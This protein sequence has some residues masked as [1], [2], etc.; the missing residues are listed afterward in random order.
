MAVVFPV[1]F[2]PTNMMTVGLLSACFF[3]SQASKSNWLTFRTSDTASLTAIS[4]TCSREYSLLYFFP[5]RLFL[6]PM[7]I[8]WTTS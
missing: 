8:S 6:T 3:S 4:T 1:P 5:V 2:M 7:M